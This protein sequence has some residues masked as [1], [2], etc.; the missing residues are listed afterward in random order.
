MTRPP[1]P[2]VVWSDFLDDYLVV[3]RVVSNREWYFVPLKYVLKLV[4]TKAT[5]PLSA[6]PTLK[7]G[8]P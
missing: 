8:T 2:R 7:P 5:T 6:M 1:P 4:P 3:V